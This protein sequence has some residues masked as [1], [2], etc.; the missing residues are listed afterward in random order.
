M[1]KMSIPISAARTLVITSCIGRLDHPAGGV[2]VVD[3]RAAVR[4]GRLDRVAEAVAHIARRVGARVGDGGDLVLAVV[5]Q[6]RVEEV[7]IGLLL[8]PVQRVEGAGIELAARVGQRDR[9]AV[10]S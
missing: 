5:R 7:R 3:R 4:T 10:V 1:M 6:R 2:E 9:V 8:Q